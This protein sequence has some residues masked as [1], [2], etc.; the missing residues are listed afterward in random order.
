ML[1]VAKLA[2]FHLEG[3]TALLLRYN[4]KV[5]HNSIYITPAP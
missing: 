1:F 3:K 5:D 2:T 4:G